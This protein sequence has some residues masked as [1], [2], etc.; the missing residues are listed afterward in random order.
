MGGILSDSSI[1]Q[2]FVKFFIKDYLVNDSKCR[3]LMTTRR[4]FE[5]RKQFKIIIDDNV[6]KQIEKDKSKVT[7]ELSYD[8]PSLIPS[9]DSTFGDSYNQPIKDCIPWNVTHLTFGDS[10]NQSIKGCIPDNVTHL[11]FGNN[12]DPIAPYIKIYCIGYLQRIST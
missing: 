12:F 11:F 4:F 9:R 1:D 6:I 3:L 5:L 7:N 8:I 2:D 10:F